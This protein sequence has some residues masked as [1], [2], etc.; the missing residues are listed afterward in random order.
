MKSRP[1]LAIGAR[2]PRP[3][4]QPSPPMTHSKDEELTF[5]ETHPLRLLRGHDLLGGHRLTGLQPRFAP[6][7]RDIDQHAASDYPVRIIRDVHDGS[8]LRRDVRGRFSVV[9]L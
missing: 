6:H 5:T 9:Q 1:S 2:P 3:Q 7:P 4:S 8:A